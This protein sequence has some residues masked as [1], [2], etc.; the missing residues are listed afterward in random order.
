MEE[1]AIATIQ[2]ILKS[3]GPV[4]ESKIFNSIFAKTI[5]DNP[6]QPFDGQLQKQQPSLKHIQQVSQ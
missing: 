3:M 2:T 4:F 5:H 1:L 6:C